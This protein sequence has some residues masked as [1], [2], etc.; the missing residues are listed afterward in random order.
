MSH[1][2]RDGDDDDDDDDQYLLNS[3]G[4]DSK[5]FPKHWVITKIQV[6]ATILHYNDH[7]YM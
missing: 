6:T 3:F 1:I 7:I 4:R 2:F 5:L